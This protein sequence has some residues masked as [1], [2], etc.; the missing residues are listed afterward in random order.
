MGGLRGLGGA[1]ALGWL[2]LAAGGPA[3]PRH[4]RL[5]LSQVHGGLG[6]S[7]TGCPRLG[8]RAE[9]EGARLRGCRSEPRRLRGTFG[10]DDR[11]VSP[12]Y[13]PAWP[14]TLPLAA[15]RVAACRV[16]ELARRAAAFPAAHSRAA[17]PRG[18]DRR[19][20]LAGLAQRACG[21]GL[22]TPPRGSAAPTSSEAGVAPHCA[23]SP[24]GGEKFL[25]AGSS[26]V[27]SCRRTWS[28]PPVAQARAPD[29]APYAYLAPWRAQRPEPTCPAPTSGLCR[30]HPAP[31]TSGQSAVDPS[32]RP[33]LRPTPSRS[34]GNL[35]LRVP[36]RVGLGPRGRRDVPRLRPR[37]P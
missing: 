28:P 22:R 14:L 34:L 10:G 17:D 25:G 23:S 26:L 3:L 2:R 6:T 35:Q 5:R 31:A 20:F 29:A 16:E 36:G 4:G 21:R 24:Q 32:A 15:K 13:E 1:G 33:R 12:A 37:A 7:N 11:C 18:K 30:L 19:L 27:L 9:G 8:L